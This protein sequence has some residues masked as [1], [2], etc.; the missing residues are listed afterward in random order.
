MLPTNLNVT[1]FFLLLAIKASLTF[2][3]SSPWRVFLVVS[4]GLVTSWQISKIA[5]EA[6]WV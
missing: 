2:I 3:A 4:R 1:Y 6:Y 5:A